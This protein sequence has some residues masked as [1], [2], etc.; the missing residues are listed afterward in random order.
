MPS[1]VGRP[2]GGLLFPTAKTWPSY[3]QAKQMSRLR[4]MARLASPG[5]LS[6]TGMA[7]TQVSWS[8]MSSFSATIVARR[9]GR[10]AAGVERVVTTAGRTNDDVDV[11]LTTDKAGT[12]AVVVSGDIVSGLLCMYMCVSVA[13][14][15]LD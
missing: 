14:I 9:C 10:G 4:T 12:N 6:S 11:L 2:S 1:L 5:T 13:W 3:E 7:S 15:G 8:G